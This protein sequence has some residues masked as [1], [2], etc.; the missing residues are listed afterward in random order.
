MDMVC[1]RI[2]FATT[3]VDISFC[4]QHS[5]LYI[6]FVRSFFLFFYKYINSLYVNVNS[7]TDDDGSRVTLY[8]KQIRFRIQIQQLYYHAQLYTHRL[9]Y[10]V[11]IKYE[12]GNIDIL[13]KTDRNNCKQYR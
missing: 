9:Q 8:R 6:L 1:R 7:T 13:L 5:I 4:F 3:V 11:C 10:Y 12:N 2:S